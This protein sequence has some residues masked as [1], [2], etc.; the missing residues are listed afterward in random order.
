MFLKGFYFACNFIHFFLFLSY[1]IEINE[2]LQYFIAV[3]SRIGYLEIAAMGERSIPKVT[4]SIGYLEICGQYQ[5]AHKHVTSRIGYLEKS[6][7]RLTT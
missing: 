2:F 4:S 7:L 5:Q 6:Q 3:T 1:P